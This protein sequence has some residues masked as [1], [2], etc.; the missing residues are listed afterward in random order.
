MTA[1]SDRHAPEIQ[2]LRA[3]AVG[4]V[5]A[6]H[7]QPDIVPG[8]FVGVDVFFVISGYLITGVLSRMAG[9][10]G[11]SLRDF[12]ARRARRILPAALVVL[13]ATF[14]A[15][16][17]ILPPVFWRVTITEIAASALYVENWVLAARAVDYLRADEAPTAVQH[18]WSLAVEEQFY[19]L[20]PLLMIGAIA[21][22]R[23]F[24]ASLRIAVL[25]AAAIAF[26]GS[27]AASVALTATDPAHAYFVTHARI[28]ELLLGGILFL[29]PRIG[30]GPPWRRAA[31]AAAGL[32]AI[33][34]S[35][36][37]YSVDTPFPGLAALLPTAGAALVILAGDAKLGRFRGLDHPV[38]GYL[39]DRSYSIYLWHWPL[40]AFYT[41]ANGA[42]GGVASVV[43]IA[44]TL[45][46]AHLSYRIVE[47]RFL[48]RPSPADL[49]KLAY[50]T[51]SLIAVVAVLSIASPTSRTAGEE[52][53]V[54][55]E[56]DPDLYP[57]PAALYAGAPVPEGVPF[58]PAIEDIGGDRP[59]VYANDCHQNQRE[60][61]PITCVLGDPNGTADIVVFGDS[62]AAQWTPALDE[63][64]RERGWRLFNFTKSACA[65]SRVDILRNGV[66]YTSCT[67]WRENAVAAILA[68]DPAMIFVSL[69]RYD[70]VEA[71]AMIE[72]L[73]SIWT[74][75]TAAGAELVVIAD[76]PLFAYDAVDCLSRDRS[77]CSAPRAASVASDTLEIAAAGLP[78]VRFVDMTDGICGPVT[79]STTVGNIVV[80]RDASHLTATYSRALAPFL[81]RAAGL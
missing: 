1:R 72:G 4:C 75:L 79:C 36:F 28:W 11:I 6:F 20:W 52:A 33:L 81:A 25:A 22:G 46:L 27:L 70:A 42:P 69:S 41:F 32:A 61:E 29:G 13:M 77:A 66:P 65:P 73:R 53:G 39:G 2:G 35:A 74:S 31:L 68:L 8:G 18:F 12:Y 57:G 56:L 50:A 63:M 17:V 45:V 21:V 34:W 47:R 48:D 59:V 40:L 44:V 67:E 71:A 3:V 24:G 64:A 54:D 7:F 76:T 5:L 51:V 78:N 62:H 26:A 19:L 58:R 60:A 30:A 38:L 43:L 23:R 14:V 80:F 37:A 15:T 55:L 10:G 9:S 49:R 16:I